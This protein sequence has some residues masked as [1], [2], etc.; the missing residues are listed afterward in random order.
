MH[1]KRNGG[2][3]VALQGPLYSLGLASARIVLYN[4][5]RVERA[6]LLAIGGFSY[7]KNKR[8]HRNSQQ[9]V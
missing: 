4:A 9:D 7:A 6:G 2:I 8:L 3:M 5:R 1:R